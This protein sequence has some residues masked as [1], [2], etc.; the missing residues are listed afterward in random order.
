MEASP[1]VERTLLVLERLPKVKRFTAV[2]R[3]TQYATEDDLIAVDLLGVVRLHG[4]N[5][6]TVF[7]GLDFGDGSRVQMLQRTDGGIWSLRWA[8]AYTGC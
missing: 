8:S 2:W 3:D 4:V 6:P 5:R 1:K 7:L